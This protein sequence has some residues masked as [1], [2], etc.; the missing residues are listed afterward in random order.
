MMTKKNFY[1]L[2]YSVYIILC[3]VFLLSCDESECDFVN[4]SF[5]RHK[6]QH[7]NKSKIYYYY[8]NTPCDCNGIEIDLCLDCKYQKTYRNYVEYYDNGEL[9]F[10]K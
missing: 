2:K 8:H 4:Q 10:G 3:L 5:R 1:K 7:C 9:I 6:V